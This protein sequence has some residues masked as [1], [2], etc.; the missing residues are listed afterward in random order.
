MITTEQYN[1]LQSQKVDFNTFLGEQKQ[2]VLRVIEVNVRNESLTTV[3]HRYYGDLENYDLIN[4]LNNFSDP[5]L[6]NGTIKL[7]TGA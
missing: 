7:V 6:I 4:N 5:S 2:A 3:V 1:D